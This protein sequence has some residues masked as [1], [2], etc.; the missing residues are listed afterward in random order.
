V[1]DGIFDLCDKLYGLQFKVVKDIPVYHE[2][3]VAYEVTE[4]DGKH[5]GILYMDF[6]PRAS[7]T[8]RSMDDVIPFP[9]NGE[10]QTIGSRDFYCV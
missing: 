7:K 9:K 10:W 6:H 1:R 3:V 4:K 5:V 8:R 2:D